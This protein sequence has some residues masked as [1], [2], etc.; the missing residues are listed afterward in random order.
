LLHTSFGDYPEGSLDVLWNAA[1]QHTAL[2]LVMGNGV[3]RGYFVI[4]ELLNSPKWMSAVGD[5]IATEFTVKL[6]AWVPDYGD[7]NSDV[8][9]PP[10]PPRGQGSSIDNGP[11]TIFSPGQSTVQGPGEAFHPIVFP[12]SSAGASAAVTQPALTVSSGLSPNDVPA[13]AIVGA[14]PFPTSSG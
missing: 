14:T 3:H 2:A 10:T 8:A 11:I 9:P 5:M 7:S 13:S 1:E 12:P 4:T 6:K